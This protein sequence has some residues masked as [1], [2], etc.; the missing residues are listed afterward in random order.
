MSHFEVVAWI[1][2][3]ILKRSSRF[4]VGRSEVVCR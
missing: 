1:D 2:C 3:A 4:A